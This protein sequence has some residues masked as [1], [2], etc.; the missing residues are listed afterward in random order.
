MEGEL[1]AGVP[2]VALVP[3]LVEIAKRAGLPTRFAG[4]A[5]IGLAIGLVALVELASAPNLIIT[6]LDLARW[7]VTGLIY[8]LAAAGLY[9]QRGQLLPGANKRVSANFAGK[10]DHPSL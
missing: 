9:D 10:R 3:G 7:G 4:L 1:L 6:T 5:A 8:G 2:V